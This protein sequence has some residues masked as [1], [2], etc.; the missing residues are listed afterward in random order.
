MA[1][2]QMARKYQRLSQER[3]MRI[4]TNPLPPLH[5]LAGSCSNAL[6]AILFL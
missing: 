2:I 6:P 4:Q 1:M 3:I 5:S